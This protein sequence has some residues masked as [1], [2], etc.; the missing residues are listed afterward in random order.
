ML[1]KYK[2][3][4]QS[5]Y[6]ARVLAPADKYLRTLGAPYIN[7]AMINKGQYNPEQKDE[8]T[9]TTLHGGI[10]Q[11]LK[12]KQPIK[13]EDLLTQEQDNRGEKLL[14]PFATSGSNVRKAGNVEKA[15][16]SRS[17][18]VKFILV[19]GPPG[20]GKSTFAWEVCRR[21]DEIESLRHYH[22]VVLLK[23]RERWVLNAVS[24]P[25]LFFQI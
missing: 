23:L 13:I 9:K 1:A 12:N 21:W 15:S 6:N 19:E 10:D 14:L 2:Q 16:Y 20:I 17:K 3:Y 4:L 18:P 8:F 22:T 7:I 11:I 25:D 24:L 5:C